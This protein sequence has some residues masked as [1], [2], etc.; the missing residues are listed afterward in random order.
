MT[1]W[2]A[3]SDGALAFDG[4]ELHLSE[5]GEGSGVGV[6]GAIG[7]GGGGW[8]PNAVG[9]ADIGDVTGDWA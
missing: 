8:K 4:N 5:E 3:G 9:V 2:D 6:D 7:G 1:K